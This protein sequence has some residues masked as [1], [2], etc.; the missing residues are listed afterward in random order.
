MYLAEQL[1]FG[2]AVYPVCGVM[3]FS[4]TMPAGLQ[5]AYVEVETTGGLFGRG[6]K[7]R[8]HLFH[9]SEINGEPTSRCYQVR[10]SRGEKGEEG[11]HNRNVLASYIHLHFASEPSLATALVDRCEAFRTGDQ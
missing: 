2:D 1:R 3:P 7:A 8:G 6:R 11:Y 4:T 9:S 10:T 5:I